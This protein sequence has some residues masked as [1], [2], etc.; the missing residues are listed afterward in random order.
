[1]RVNSPYSHIWDSV[2]VIG[3]A[4]S[5]YGHLPLST[6]AW[7]FLNGSKGFPTRGSWKLQDL[8]GPEPLEL[9]HHFW[10]ILRSKQVT[11]PAQISEMGKYTPAL[12]EKSCKISCPCFPNSHSSPLYLAW[13]SNFFLFTALHKLGP[14]SLSKLIY[15]PALLDSLQKVLPLGL[16]Y[17]LFPLP[18]MLL[19]QIFVRLNSLLSLNVSSSRRPSL[20]TSPSSFL[21]HYPVLSSCGP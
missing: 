8:L 14:A 1:M 19:S 5:L 2:L 10:H 20:S 21:P 11:R 12:T 16:S 4:L 17:V 7:D 18:G 13:S 3:L 6:L 9:T 15:N